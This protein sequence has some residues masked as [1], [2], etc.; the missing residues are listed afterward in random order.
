METEG[1]IQQH[2]TIALLHLDGRLWTSAGFSGGLP[3]D[4]WAWIANAVATEHSVDPDDV[5][6]E[7]TEDGD[8]VT[9]DGVPVYRLSIKKTLC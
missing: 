7:E 8:V 5:G 4:G 9:V 2:R 3:S 1:M 6:C